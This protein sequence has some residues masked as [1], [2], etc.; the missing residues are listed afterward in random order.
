MTGAS[1]CAFAPG[2]SGPDL[3][4][5]ACGLLVDLDGTLIDSTVPVHRAWSAFAAR[6][7]LDPAEVIRFAQGRPVSAD[8]RAARSPL[9]FRKAP[10]NRHERRE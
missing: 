3:L 1:G 4:A 9:L 10:D 8:F 5:D 6:H 7:R 2:S